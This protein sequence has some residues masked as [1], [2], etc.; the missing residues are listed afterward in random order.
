MGIP[1]SPS[2]KST[3]VIAGTR[4]IGREEPPFRKGAAVETLVA[5]PGTYSWQPLTHSGPSIGGVKKR[6]TQSNSMDNRAIDVELMYCLRKIF[7][8]R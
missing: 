3:E 1:S 6:F 5:C 8:V 7:R 2:L 4:S